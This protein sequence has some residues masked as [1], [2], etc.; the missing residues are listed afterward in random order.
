[1]RASGVVEESVAAVAGVLVNGFGDER[2]TVLTLLW[3]AAVI[4]G[5]LVRAR[6][7]IPRGRDLRRGDR[8]CRSSGRDRSHASYVGLCVAAAALLLSGRAV[9]AELGDLLELA[10][11]EADHDGLTGALARSAF[12]AALD[13]AL[14]S[15]PTRTARSRS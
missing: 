7:N 1:M 15:G 11:Y 5:A 2:V 10:R 14:A 6:S 3:L 8:P 4:T 13:A 12:R 9:M